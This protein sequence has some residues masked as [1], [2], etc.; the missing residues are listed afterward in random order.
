[1]KRI[2]LVY[3]TLK[4]LYTGKGLSA[5]EIAHTLK[6]SRA[7]VSNDLNKLCTEGKVSKN[8]GRPVLFNPIENG[9]YDNGE[10]KID[11][12]TRENQSLYTAVE[13]AK[14]AILYPP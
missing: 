9:V 13:Q 11:R 1:M 5:V 12:F 8:S 7:N 14:A 4:K 6:L 2:D 10:S 3:E